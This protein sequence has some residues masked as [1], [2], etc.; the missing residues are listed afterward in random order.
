MC[1]DEE[2]KGGM[3]VVEGG[4]EVGLPEDEELE[5]ASVVAGDGGEGESEERRR[6]RPGVPVGPEERTSV[7][8]VETQ[9]RVPLQPERTSRGQA[10]QSSAPGRTIAQIL[11]GCKFGSVAGEELCA[12]AGDLDLNHNMTYPKLG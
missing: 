1:G 4:E 7:P 6:R 8:G 5:S 11:P 2:G 9:I 10:K 3:D 12:K